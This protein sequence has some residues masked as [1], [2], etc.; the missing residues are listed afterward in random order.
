MLPLKKNAVWTAEQ[1]VEFLTKAKIPMRLACNSPHGYPLICSIWYIF[2]GEVFWC[3]SQ[4][5]SKIIRCLEENSKC[6]FEI[7]VDQP[8]YKGVRG[9]GDVRILT[10]GVEETLNQ[11]LLRYLDD[12]ENSLASWLMSRVADE[13][14]IKLTPRWVNNWDYTER[15]KA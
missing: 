7:S 15:M 1:T 5:N 13:C 12:N 14:L 9:Q 6:G 3:A 10:E 4:K 8:P 2:D 11:L